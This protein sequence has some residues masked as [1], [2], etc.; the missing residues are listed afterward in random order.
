M[1]ESNPETRPDIDQA[2]GIELDVN[3]TAVYATALYSYAL[4]H[5]QELCETDPKF[6]KYTQLI[7]QIASHGGIIMLRWSHTES[8]ISELGN[9]ATALEWYTANVDA[10]SVRRITTNP[11]GPPLPSAEAQ[12]N[13]TRELSDQ[14]R[15]EVEFFEL[16]NGLKISIND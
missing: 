7:S 16:T 11:L 14:L 15:Q 6:F 4:H 1:F 3:S 10:G 9:I 5:G 8:S 12:T 2:R 13:I